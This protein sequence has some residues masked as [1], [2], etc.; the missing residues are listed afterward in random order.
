[1]ASCEVVAKATA[2]GGSGAVAV[3][4]AVVRAVTL[5]KGRR[6][7]PLGIQLQTWFSKIEGHI[8]SKALRDL[9]SNRLLSH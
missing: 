5:P 8:K 6:S 1:M 3:A 4:L 2:N 9:G 7:C